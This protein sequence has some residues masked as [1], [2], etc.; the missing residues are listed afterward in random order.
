MYTKALF[1]FW[2]VIFFEIRRFDCVFHTFLVRYSFKW[3]WARVCN[4]SNLHNFQI[5]WLRILTTEPMRKPDWIFSLFLNYSTLFWI[6]TNYWLID[7]SLIYL[8]RL[9]FLNYKEDLLILYLLVN[10][11]RQDKSFNSHLTSLKIISWIF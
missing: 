6:L 1:T 10:N 11:K 8:L 9:C 7:C 4:M 3:L 5:C 2:T